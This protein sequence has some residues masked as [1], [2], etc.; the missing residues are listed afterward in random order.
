MTY[1]EKN[2][3]FF[4]KKKKKKLPYFLPHNIRDEFQHIYNQIHT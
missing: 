2:E 1:I 3:R 4:A